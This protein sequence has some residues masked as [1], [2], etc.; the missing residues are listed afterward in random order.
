VAAAILEGVAVAFCYPAYET[1]TLWD[2]SIDTLEPYRRRGLARTCFEFLC[3]HM[4]AH[5]KVPVWGAL[6][7]NSASLSLAARLGF[8]EVDRSIVF[9]REGDWRLRS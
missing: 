9:L 8:E 4:A 6:A 1:E 3:D 7:S 5:G 2:V